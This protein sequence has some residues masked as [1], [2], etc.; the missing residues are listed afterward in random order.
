MFLVKWSEYY[1]K[2]EKP[3]PHMLQG[4]SPVLRGLILLLGNSICHR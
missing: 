4:E 1:Y 2:F 3:T